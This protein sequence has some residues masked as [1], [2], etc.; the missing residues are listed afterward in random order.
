MTGLELPRL[1]MG[2]AGIGNLYAPVSDADAFATVTAA[3][4]GG[5]RYFDTAPHYGFGLSEQ[6]L[7]AALADLDPAGEAIVSTKVGR[8]LDPV[9]SPARERHGFVDGAPFEPRFDYGRDAVLRSMDH[10]LQRLRRDRIN[11][12]LAHDLGS[13]THGEDADAHMRSFLDGGYAAMRELKEQGAIDAI[14]IGVNETAVCEFLLARIDLDFILLAGRYTLL[15]RSAAERVFPLCLEKGV[16]VIAGGP[17]N[18]GILAAPLAAQANPHYDYEA[19]STDVWQRAAAIEQLCLSQGVQLPV[20]A[21]QFP[22]RHPAVASVVVGLSSPGEVEDAL[23]R[24]DAE[25]PAMLWSALNG[26]GGSCL[27]AAARPQ[28]ILLHESDTILVC[29]TPIRAGDVL[30]IDGEPVISPGPVEVGHKIARR[31][32]RPGD[33]VLKYGAPIGS[34]TMPTEAGGWVHVHNMKSDYIATHN[35]DT[36]SQEGR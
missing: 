2:A 30:T 31:P 26:A 10:S 28:A 22:L 8:L 16:R 12:L 35:R 33:R 7:G 29:V 32:L 9:A 23:E 20:A 27:N 14:G 34:I 18:S 6:R 1:G 19:P 15:D 25:V 4:R 21:L 24:I 36:V 3:W 5:M 11:L 17:Y 13:L